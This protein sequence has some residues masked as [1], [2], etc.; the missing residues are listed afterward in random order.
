MPIQAVTRNNISWKF[1]NLKFGNKSD[2]EGTE[3]PAPALVTQEN[4]AE[5]ITYLGGAQEVCDI[6]NVQAI[7]D[8]QTAFKISCKVD[9]DGN[10]EGYDEERNRKIHEE[11]TA[12]G[13]GLTKSG[14]RDS[15]EKLNKQVNEAVRKALT[16]V[17]AR[18]KEQAFTTIGALTAQ[19]GE[20]ELALATL[21][22][23]T[24]P[25]KKKQKITVSSVTTTE[26]A[27]AEAEDEDED[28]E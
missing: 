24:K 27:Q 11:G 25:R 14:L 18:A 9:K 8:A 4:L 1:R 13:G 5:Y 21:I 22:T 20:L 7:R 3:Y 12:K 10:I 15:I 2:L 16:I 19:V 17:D 28:D 23:N 26:S 6:L